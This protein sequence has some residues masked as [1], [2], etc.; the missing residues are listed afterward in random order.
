MTRH[1]PNLPSPPAWLRRLE[2]VV[3][4]RTFARA[5]NVKAPSLARASAGTSLRLFRDFTAACMELALERPPVA[6]YLRERLGREALALGTTVRRL[7]FVRQGHEMDVIRY[8]Y[9]GIGIELAGGVPGELRFGPCYFARRYAPRDCWLMSAFDEGFIR[10]VS[11]QTH[12][13]LSFS[14]RLTEG[15][16]CCLARMEQE[17]PQNKE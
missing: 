12:A 9:R 1:V 13:E 4:M 5:F 14:C 15:A 6:E 2:V 16:P 17:Q 11:G 3:L 7:L 10:G 8:L